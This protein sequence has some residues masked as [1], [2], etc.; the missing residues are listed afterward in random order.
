MSENWR[1]R[2]ER[3][4][5]AHPNPDQR[6]LAMDKLDTKKKGG[7]KR[8][9]TAAQLAKLIKEKRGNLSAV[10]DAAGVA[11]QTVYST[12][13]RSEKLK[14]VLEDAR[15]ALLDHAESSLYSQVLAG[16]TLATIFFLKTQGKRRGYVER[17]E[18]AGAEDAPPIRVITVS[19]PE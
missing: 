2:R 11:R 10:A 1:E 4:E 5:F 15:E 6:V 7:A 3:A 12:L 16:N 17:H 19:K 14:T 9:L 8:K 13:Q 18:V